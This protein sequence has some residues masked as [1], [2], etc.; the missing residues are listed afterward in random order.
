MDWILSARS[1]VGRDFSLRRAGTFSR[2]FLPARIGGV[3]RSLDAPCSYQKSRLPSSGP[4]PEAPS[5]TSARRDSTSIGMVKP[6]Y[7]KYL[8]SVRNG[9]QKSQ[10]PNINRCTRTSVVEEL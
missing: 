10:F 9:D 4:C 8:R 2:W 5:G 3:R 6:N 7:Q 1:M